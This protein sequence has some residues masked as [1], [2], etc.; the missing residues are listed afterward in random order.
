MSDCSYHRNRYTNGG[1]HC[2]LPATSLDNNA[3][4]ALTLLFYNLNTACPEISINE[5]SRLG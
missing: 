4:V 3:F 1:L 5:L 2:M